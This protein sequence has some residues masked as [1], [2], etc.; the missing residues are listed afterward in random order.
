MKIALLGDIAFFGKF[1]ITLN[2]SIKSYF[3]AVA[4]YLHGF[5]YVIGNFETPLLAGGHAY[6]YKSAYIKAHP[7]NVELLS[8][9]NVGIV[10]LA[11]NHMFDYGIEGYVSTIELLKKHN[12]RY[13]GVEDKVELLEDSNNKIALHGYCCYSTNPVGVFT[14]KGAGINRL[15]VSEVTN[16]LLR[17]QKEGYFNVI[18]FHL[19]Q[20]HVNYPNYDH[21]I[22][23]RQLAEICPYVFYGHHPHVLQGIEKVNDAL[24]AY[25]LGN[26]CF[27][28]VY[29]PKS[30]E[31]LIKQTENNRSAIILSLEFTD[32]K[33]TDYEPVDVFSGEKEMILNF[34]KSVENL[35]EYS[36]ALSLDKST[37]ISRRNELLCR[38]IGNRKK[39]RDLNWYLKRLNPTSVWMLITAY[40][41]KHL[42]R[43]YVLDKLNSQIKKPVIHLRNCQ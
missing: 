32:G 8:Y 9:L 14:G 41:N 31:P 11:N 7:A 36:Q 18:S 29:T 38:F 40:R 35:K 24:I 28:D 43:K 27:D 26:F 25:S 16:N 13:F 30:N 2:K 10:N 4:E 17:F 15:D 3:A 33:I 37:Y 23:A 39:M 12:I 34:Q 21:M 22:M 19:G 42:Y 6:G 5:D 20:E 1:D